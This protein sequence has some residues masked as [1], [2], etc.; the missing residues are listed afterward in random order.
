LLIYKY[1]YSTV[2]KIIAAMSEKIKS[3]KL[4]NMDLTK[5]VKNF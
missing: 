4:L 5:I 1:E 3:E 2:Y